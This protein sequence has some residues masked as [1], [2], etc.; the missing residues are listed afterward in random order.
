[1]RIFN[2]ILKKFSP[3][4]KTSELPLPLPLQANVSSLHQLRFGHPCWECCPR[5]RTGGTLG[6]GRIFFCC[7]LITRQNWQ[8]TELW[9]DSEKAELYLC[10]CFILRSRTDVA[11][12]CCSPP[13]HIRHEVPLLQGKEPREDV[14]VSSWR[15]MSLLGQEIQYFEASRGWLFTL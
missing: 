11:Q 4:L 13:G 5:L 3:I 14:N 8:F 12:S 15:W 7:A 2:K 6:N 10:I 9:K 1:M